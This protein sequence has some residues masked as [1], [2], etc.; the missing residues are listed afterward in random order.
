MSSNAIA[1]RTKA[2]ANK[3]NNGSGNVGGGSSRKKPWK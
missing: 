2:L 1:K 3:E